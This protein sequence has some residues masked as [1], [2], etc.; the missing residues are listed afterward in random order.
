MVKNRERERERERIVVPTKKKSR[1]KR[2][3]KETNSF[4]PSHQELPRVGYD[5]GQAL[6]RVRNHQGRLGGDVFLM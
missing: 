6:S 1:K 3:R 4:S 5:G 2:T